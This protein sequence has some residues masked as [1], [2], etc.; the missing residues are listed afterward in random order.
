MVMKDKL[1]KNHHHRLYYRFRKL[2]VFTLA[3][4]SFGTIVAVPTYIT[5]REIENQTQHAEQNIVQDD[6]LQVE[7]FDF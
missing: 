3:I 2:G 4:I 5:L 7:D 6:M 1:F